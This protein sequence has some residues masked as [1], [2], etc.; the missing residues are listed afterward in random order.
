MNC[1]HGRVKNS[2]LWLKKSYC[3]QTLALHI[4]QFF[5]RVRTM[6]TST[7]TS[8]VI[9]RLEYTLIQE[10]FMNFKRKIKSQK[11]LEVLT[12]CTSI[13]AWQISLFVGQWRCKQ[14]EKDQIVMPLKPQ[15]Y[16]NRT[17]SYILDLF[18]L[19]HPCSIFDTQYGSFSDP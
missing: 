12:S 11:A 14:E 7:N 8:R 1:P 18:I 6:N 15:Y 19:D 16:I 9:L 5:F 10:L 2:Y 13:E 4:G 3:R 17:V